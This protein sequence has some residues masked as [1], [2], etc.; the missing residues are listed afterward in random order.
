[1]DATFALTIIGTLFVLYSILPE[2]KRVRIRYV[3]GFPEKMCI[4]FLIVFMFLSLLSGIFYSVNNGKDLVHP[5]IVFLGTNLQFI[6]ELTYI[7]TGTAIFILIAYNLVSKKV[8]IKNFD[9]FLEII[10]N[11]FNEKKYPVLIALLDENYDNIFQNQQNVFEK[12]EHLSNDELFME[13]LENF[14]SDI[15]KK[16]RK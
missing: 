14:Q 5:I 7:F 11:C 16:G 6:Y 9:S 1:M 10:D 13:I 2:Q 15:F 12:N 8:K 4:C 3:F